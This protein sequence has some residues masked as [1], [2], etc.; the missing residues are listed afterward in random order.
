MKLRSILLGVTILLSG[1]EA[2]A[3]DSWQ[4]LK[5]R[6]WSARSTALR[7]FP[8]FATYELRI[9]SPVAHVRDLGP[10]IRTV[11][12]R[13]TDRSGHAISNAVVAFVQT[14]VDRQ[15]WVGNG[16]YIEN[17]DVTDGDGQF[18][19]EGF[20]G[21]TDV[22]FPGNTD[23]VFFRGRQ[24]VWVAGVGDGPDVQEF[25]WPDTAILKWQVPESVA[26]PNQVVSIRRRKALVH[27][28]KPVIP[29]TVDSDNV[30]QANLLPGEYLLTVFPDSSDVELASRH[31]VEVAQVIAT[32]GA[33]LTVTQRT[34]NGVI[35]GRCKQVSSSTY[36]TISRQN[37]P[38]HERGVYDDT[39]ED[40]VVPV[41]DM[42]IPNSQGEFVFRQLPPG[43]YVIRQR[44]TK[45]GLGP[46]HSVRT[47][48]GEVTENSS[49][50]QLAETTEHDSLREKIEQILNDRSDYS[51]I[52]HLI[53]AL[54]DDPN[55]I[56]HELSEIL[57]DED[58]PVAWHQLITEGL[59]P[60]SPDCDAL[61]NGLVAAIPTLRLYDRM[62][63]FYRLVAITEN[64]DH[65]VDQLELLRQSGRQ[66]IR[67][68]S[69]QFLAD[70][71]GKHP[72]QT[73]RV[74][75]ILEQS[76]KDSQLRNAAI[77]R[78][79][80]LKQPIA[81]TLLRERVLSAADSS[82]KVHST[83]LIWQLGGG[84]HDFLAAAHEALQQRAL[85]PKLYACR[86]LREFSKTQQLPETT[87]AQ[88][89]VL[90]SISILADNRRTEYDRLFSQTVKTARQALG[91]E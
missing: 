83:F 26:R 43:K 90:A 63:A 54:D 74:V 67:L 39:V 18:K 57:K 19:V 30:V 1:S 35:R 15:S 50:V 86:Q 8:D 14:A 61:V 34:G 56:W 16:S 52:H 28:F 65:V 51:G 78:L 66:E 53:F 40:M 64:V 41:L 81:L 58:A 13:L 89:R 44:S 25:Q 75:A 70:V 29:V 88:L 27:N 6:A 87:Q 48:R 24:R 79:A 71:A 10:P 22:G 91:L 7:S 72:E 84:E 49:A 36:V 47:W 77:N 42:Q 2:Q 11:S 31:A 82:D 3:D 59:C 80:T 55:L 37:D 5:Q 21:N 4:F 68:G 12:G 38:T 32:E 60:E 46:R 23:L 45:R 85:S 73:E 69:L 20:A 33:D 76:L 9:S 62:N 17:F